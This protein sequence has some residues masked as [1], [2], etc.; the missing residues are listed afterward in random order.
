M[1]GPF[2][3]MGKTHLS[4]GEIAH[5]GKALRRRRAQ[6]LRRNLRPGGKFPPGPAL[7]GKSAQRAK[8][9]AHYRIPGGWGDRSAGNREGNRQK[10][11]KP[12]TTVCPNSGRRLFFAFVGH[13]IPSLPISIADF[14]KQTRGDDLIRLRVAQPPSPEGKAGG[15]IKRNGRE[16]LLPRRVFSA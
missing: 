4:R 11:L 12:Q 1:G 8:P 3:G 2:R 5:S 9:A 6:L 15:R 16:D 13:K 7:L 14:G 10:Y